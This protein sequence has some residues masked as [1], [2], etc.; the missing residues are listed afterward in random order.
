MDILYEIL[1]EKSEIKLKNRIVFLKHPTVFE[2]L[3][4]DGLVDYFKRIGADNGLLPEADLIKEACAGGSWD[5]EKDEETKLLN[6]ELNKMQVQFSKIKEPFLKGRAESRINEIQSSL[7]VLQKE[8][9][10]I[11][12]FS[13]EKYA[14]VKSSMAC[15]RE[16]LYTDETL[17]QKIADGEEGDFITPY[18]GKIQELSSK[19]NLLKAAFKAEMLNCIYIFQENPYHIFSQNIYQLT[20]FKRD[21]LIYGIS[22]FSKLKNSEI[23]EGIKNDPIRVFDWQRNDKVEEDA[24]SIRSMAN[25]RGGLENLSARDKLT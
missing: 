15:C 19:E 7:S 1:D 3:K 5:K 6:W 9:D 2:G 21:L 17:T 24:E 20:T 18:I 8:R 22:L 4:Q 16:N 14:L 11:T 13:L 12:R 25:R 10:E 23:P